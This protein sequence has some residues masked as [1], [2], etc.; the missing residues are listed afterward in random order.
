[1]TC[2]CMCVCVCTCV[3]ASSLARCDGVSGVSVP[4]QACLVRS[5]LSLPTA[6]VPNLPLTPGRARRS[7]LHVVVVMVICTYVRC[8]VIVDLKGKLQQ[9]G[10]C[11]PN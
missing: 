10:F 8:T 1:M 5:V 4:R 11:V 9:S 6:H 2:V 7:Y 3:R